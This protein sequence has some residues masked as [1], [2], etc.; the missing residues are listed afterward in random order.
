[1]NGAALLALQVVDTAIDAIAHRRSRLSELAARREAAGAVDQ[2]RARMA[3]ADRMR[4]AAEREIDSAEAAAAVVTAKRARLEAQLKR[5]IAPREAEAL[6]TEIAVLDAERGEIDE[7]ELAAMEAQAAAETSLAELAA[8]ESA[9]IAAL[10]EAERV[11]A[12]ANG[13]LDVE[14]EALAAQRAVAAAAMSTD[15][16]SAYDA[17]RRQFGGVGVAALEGHRCNACHLDLSATE[18][19]VVRSAPSGEPGEC[20]HCGR[21]LVR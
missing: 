21:Y 3:D 8:L 14:L 10:A 2:L 18:L 15:E 1:M 17:A 9:L 11:L 19:D 13:A 7:R 12:E 16:L 20:P 6:M 4:S 5:V